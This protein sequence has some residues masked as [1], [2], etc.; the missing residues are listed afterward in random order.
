[1]KTLITLFFLCLIIGT[2]LSTAKSKSKSKAKDGRRHKPDTMMEDGDLQL[3]E[4]S[5]KI[6]LLKRGCGIALF[7][8][9]GDME[10][11]NIE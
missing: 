11:K 5:V 9:H 2:V 7:R 3:E 4:G 8:D 10:V 1:M 6:Q